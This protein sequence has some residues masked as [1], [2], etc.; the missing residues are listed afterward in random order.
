[1]ILFYLIL[2][3]VFIANISF[4]IAFTRKGFDNARKNNLK[5]TKKRDAQYLTFS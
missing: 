3:L 1:M 2:A 5:K 4:L